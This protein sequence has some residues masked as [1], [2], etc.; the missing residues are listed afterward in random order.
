MGQAGQGHSLGFT[1]PRFLQVAVERAW[2]SHVSFAEG[3]S[4]A[5][6]R[7]LKHL[8]RAELRELRREN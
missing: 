5:E 7:S 8:D 3:I 1:S 2:A 6:H 4:P